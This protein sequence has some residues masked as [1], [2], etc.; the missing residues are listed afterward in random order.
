LRRPSVSGGDRLRA[1]PRAE[2]LCGHM[3]LMAAGR[4]ERAGTNV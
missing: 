4:A 2:L 1:V 3:Q